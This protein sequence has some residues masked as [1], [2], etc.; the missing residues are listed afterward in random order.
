M[1]SKPRFAVVCGIADYGSESL[2]DYVFKNLSD[3]YDC[4]RINF[5]KSE[6]FNSQKNPYLLRLIS[7]PIVTFTILKNLLD[8]RKIVVIN[9]LPLFYL[10]P[11]L[12]NRRIFV[13]ADWIRTIF[14]NDFEDLSLKSRF[15]FKV[16]R[17]ILKSIKIT[18]LCFTEDLM[19][20]F[21]LR[22][23]IDQ[24]NLVLC[25]PPR[26]IS[27]PF[28]SQ[29][30]LVDEDLPSSLVDEDLPSSLVDKDLPRFIF[31]GGDFVRKGGVE[32]LSWI[33]RNPELEAKFIFVT[34][35]M[36][37]FKDSRIERIT[38]NRGDHQKLT[39]LLSVPGILVLPTRQ[40]AFPVVVIEAISLGVPVLTLPTALGAKSL[41]Q[42]GIN[43][44]IEPNNE[45][46]FKKLEQLC[47]DSS[48]YWNILKD[49]KEWLPNYPQLTA[50][51]TDVLENK[52]GAKW[53]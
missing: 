6:V 51:F 1:K 3:N 15:V 32:L 2:S 42:E 38:I 26:F 31:I 27:G 14:Y 25:P 17:W 40:D 36:P 12:L 33:Q 43:G 41:I 16:Q 46:F 29:N 44:F 11:I 30:S 34:N 45:A 47:L 37:Q 4:V 19:S 50:R 49:A 9:V 5:P 20:E 18:F 24:R 23:K 53:K 48:I 39:K 22:Y 52:M 28:E 21:S 10:W 8:G 35:S 13:F 7:V